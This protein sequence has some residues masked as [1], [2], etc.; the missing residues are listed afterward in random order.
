MR[1]IFIILL[2]LVGICAVP[3]V[4]TAQASKVVKAAVKASKTAAKASTKAAEKAAKA[5]KVN[6]GVASKMLRDAAGRAAAR[7]TAVVPAAGMQTRVP[8]LNSVEPYTR[9]QVAVG[10][11]ARHGRRNNDRDVDVPDSTFAT[12][13]TVIVSTYPRALRSAQLS[14]AQFD[15][16]ASDSVLVI[17]DAASLAAA[18]ATAEL[19]SVVSDEYLPRVSARTV[20]ADTIVAREIVIMQADSTFAPVAKAKPVK[21]GSAVRF[22]WGADAGASID[23]TGNDMSAVDF[24]AFFGMRRGWINFLGVGAEADIVTSNSCRYYPLFLDFR[25]NFVNRPTLFF[26]GLRVGASLNY[27]ENNWHQVGLYG[28]TGV[29]INLARSRNFC[30]HIFV[31]YTYRQRRT[32]DAEGAPRMPDLHYATFKLGVTF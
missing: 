3:V 20:V 21:E 8:A 22:A 12:A 27:Y 17:V 24:S 5:A 28:L 10:D 16:L 13:D 29:G 2:L 31:G 1:R 26:W 11:D 15:S 19:D 9:R 25:T 30:S 18:V 14:A 6:P 32:P 7:G 23:M 4:S